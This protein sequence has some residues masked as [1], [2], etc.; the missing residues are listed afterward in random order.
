LAVECA[1]KFANYFYDLEDNFED[2]FLENKLLR[3]L[4]L[5]DGEGY[6]VNAEGKRVDADGNLL[7]DIGARIDAAGNRID[8]N[9]NP[10]IDDDDAINTLEFVDDLGVTKDKPQEKK[11]TTTRGSKRKKVEEPAAQ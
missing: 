8:I 3:K 2:T 11:K 6:L 9:D 1:S 10:L 5:L 4:N 7:D